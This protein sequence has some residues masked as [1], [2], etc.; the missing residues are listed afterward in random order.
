MQYRGTLYADSL[1]NTL[2]N[3]LHRSQTTY[4]R[5]CKPLKKGHLDN[6]HTLKTVR[7]VSNYRRKWQPCELVPKELEAETINIDYMIMY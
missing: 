2:I 6:Q 7:K 5:K 3:N 1:K 4:F